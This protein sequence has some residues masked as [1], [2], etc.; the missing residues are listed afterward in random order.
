MLAAAEQIVSSQGVVFWDWLVIIA[1]GL[2]MLG[3]GVYYSLRT[4]STEEYLLGGRSM[5][6]SMIGLSLFS[7]LFST[8]TY[9]A[10]P[11][12]MINKGP[13]ALC[14][15]IGLPGCLR[16]CLYGAYSADHGS[17]GHQRIRIARD[18]AWTRQ[19]APCFRD[20]S[21][22]PHALDGPDHFHYIR[23]NP[24]AGSWS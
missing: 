18:A 3:I 17:P 2:G 8:I 22:H 1:Y 12:E 24:R 15:M 6:S 14:W 11:G 10:I 5:A 16:G 9:L 19:S 21:R 7:T 13:V 20:L 23:E 4:K